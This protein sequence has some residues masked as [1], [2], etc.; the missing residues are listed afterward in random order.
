MTEGTPSSSIERGSGAFEALAAAIA[1]VVFAVCLVVASKQF[2][3][4]D[5][6]A[7][8][9]KVRGLLGPVAWTWREAFLPQQP[10]FNWAYR[11]LSFETF[12]YVGN[13]LFG[14]Q[15]FGY[16]VSSLCVHFAGGVLFWILALRI[17][18]ERPVA[19]FAALL[20]VTRLPSLSDI[21]FVSIFSYVLCKF[22]MLSAVLL[23]LLAVRREGRSLR[24]ILVTGSAIS[25][26]LALLSN[27]IAIVIPAVVT[28]ALVCERRLGSERVPWWRIARHTAP[29]VLVAILWCIVRFKLVALV[30]RPDLYTPTIGLYTLQ[31][32]EFLIVSSLGS[33]LSAAVL[34]LWLVAPLGFVA[35]RPSMR[36]RVGQ[37]P[38]CAAGVGLVWFVSAGSIFASVA[39]PQLRFAILAEVPVCLW[40]GAGASLAWRSA[41]THGRAL[42]E[43]VAL[44]S[45]VAAIPYGALWTNWRTPRGDHARALLSLVARN[46]SLVDA[47]IVLLHSGPNMAPADVAAAHSY[48]IWNGAAFKAVYPERRLGFEIRDASLTPS[49]VAC[50]RCVFV[51]LRPDL[52]LEMVSDPLSRP[53]DRPISPG[54]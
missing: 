40:I 52:S 6:F 19:A 47:K 34:M 42:L 48:S 12:F 38:V 29:H 16:L 41:R 14:L 37:W 13:L 30:D 25:T 7:Y 46:P 44:L 23:A 51:A 45:M 32:A 49:E 54:S 4:G 28:A 27:E 1:I 18:L 11:P 35:V 22:W 39:F 36:R 15:P 3:W 43:C 53:Q 24:F 50:S 20:S 2:F 31:N 21:F 8:L 5:D 33:T 26:A 17:G 9:A 10:G